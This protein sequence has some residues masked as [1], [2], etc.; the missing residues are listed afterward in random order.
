MTVPQS[1]TAWLFFPLIM[2]GW[3][4]G[5]MSQENV[6]KANGY[7]QEGVAHLET[8]RQQAF[9]SFQKA[10]QMNPNHKEAHYSL[11]D[12]YARQGKYPEAEHEFQQALRINSDYSEASNY[13][14]E[15]YARQSRWHEAI[16]AYRR[17]LS[18]PLYGTPDLARYN[19]GLA[20]AHQGDLEGAAQAFQDALL[21]DPP[22]VPPAA[23]HLEL[24]RI[25]QQLGYNIK[26]RQA[27]AR[28]SSLDRGGP[29]AAAAEKLLERL[30]P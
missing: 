30:K 26:A 3:A 16:E 10:I 15:I 9:V 28:V 22:N 14:G 23:V 13:L 17:A 2:I 8:D 1:R 20:L 25:Y 12:L 18:N 29:Y 4:A 21:I 11:G 27:L 5:C 19:L 7:Y 24:G 6:K